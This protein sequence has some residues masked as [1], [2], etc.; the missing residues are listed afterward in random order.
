MITSFR[1]LFK[2]GFKNVWSN[3]MMSLASVCVLFAC[4]LM[5]GTAFLFIV[6]VNNVISDLGK[7]NIITVYL[8]TDANE[9]EVKQVGQEIKNIANIKTCDFVSKD[10]AMNE[11]SQMMGQSFNVIKEDGN[12][13]PDAYR[14]TIEDPQQYQD[15][16][17]QVKAIN[18]VDTISDRSDIANKLARI[19]HLVSNVGLWV[20]IFMA[21]VSLFIISNT[22]KITMYNRRLE[23]SIMKSVGATNTFIRMPFIVEGMIIGIFSA[24]LSMFALSFL[25]NS[26]M[27]TILKIVPITVYR[28]SPLTPKVIL[29]FLIIGAMFG[30]LG[31]IISINKYLRKEGGIILV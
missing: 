11:Y 29:V 18:K 3:R 30:I 8:K 5:T 28:F 20:I 9:Q 14:I 13:L 22:I 2:E 6:N 12:F 26:V 4:L 21:V 15:T 16:I 23:I 10:E 19:N 24:I 31:G 1:Y 7:E 27:N 25:Y 17:N